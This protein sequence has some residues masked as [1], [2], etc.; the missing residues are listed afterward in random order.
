MCVAAAA[1]GEIPESFERKK[2]MKAFILS[3]DGSLHQ[4]E[5]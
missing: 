2:I 4:Q 3:F 5:I 1:G